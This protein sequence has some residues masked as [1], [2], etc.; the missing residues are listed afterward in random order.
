MALHGALLV[1][2]QLVDLIAS[3]IDF[4]Q[5]RNYLMSVSHAIL[6]YVL[7]QVLSSYQDFTTETIDVCKALVTYKV[8]YTS[9]KREEGDMDSQR[10]ISILAS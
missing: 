8:I 2:N 4:G 7:S 3:I 5:N 6:K 1:P 10:S 9:E